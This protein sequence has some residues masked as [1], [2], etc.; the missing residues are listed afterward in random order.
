MAFLI[1]THFLAVREDR[2]PG[3]KHK[4]ANLL[5]IKVPPLEDSLPKSSLSSPTAPLIKEFLTISNSII[6][7]LNKSVLSSDI[8]AQTINY[9][10][11]LADWQVEQVWGWF[12]KLD[13]LSDINMEDRKVLVQNSLME[14]LAFGLARRSMNIGNSLLLGEGVFLD[15][16]T[17][18]RAGI[19]EI[20]QRVLQLSSKLNEL[21]LVDEEYV[22]LTVIV[23][24]NPG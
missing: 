1:M 3:G 19:G 15:I 22:C 8:Q 16:D 18:D 17:A 9:V 12:E 20:T 4:N 21:R 2:T 5:K 23:L 7:P 24:L 14:I 10:I 6:P 13:F 11:Q